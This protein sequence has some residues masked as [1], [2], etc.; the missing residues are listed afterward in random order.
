MATRFK[1]LCGV[2]LLVALLFMGLSIASHTTLASQFMK[3]PPA[4]PQ[5]HKFAG[6]L[7][8]S[9]PGVSAIPVHT[10][11]G[12]S[13]NAANNASTPAF[14]K[15]DV[16]TYFNAHGFYAG[17]LVKGAHLKFLSIQFV[18]A[19]EASTLMAG[20]SVGRPDDYLVCYV[21]VQGPFQVKSAE[22]P[23]TA[24]GMSTA[25]TGDAVFDAHTGNLL[26]WGVY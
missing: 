2:A 12:V 19:K 26:V 18:T 3:Q 4:S 7:T 13:A 16:I 8:Y 11:S 15:N 17:P 25:N 5:P 22:A 14:T 24:K 10:T 21:K 9:T 1:V 23:P 20:E 6:S